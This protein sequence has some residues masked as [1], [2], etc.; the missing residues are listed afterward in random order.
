MSPEASLQVSYADE[1]VTEWSASVDD[2]QLQIRVK[3]APNSAATLVAAAPRRNK[4]LVKRVQ[5]DGSG[6]GVTVVKA[7]EMVPPPPVSTFFAE[8]LIYQAEQLTRALTPATVTATEV[9]EPNASNGR[10][11]RADF[12]A[13]GQRIEFTIDVPAGGLYEIEAR[14]KEN[15]SRGI[16]QPYVDGTLAG[17]EINHLYPGRVFRG[18]EFR[19]RK[20]AVRQL[21]AG[22]HTVA[23]ESTGKS[24]PSYAV[25]VDYLRLTPTAAQDRAVFEVESCRTGS[26]K[27]VDLIRDAAASPARNGACEDLP[28]TEIGDWVEYQ[29]TVPKPGSYRIS[30]MVKKHAV[31][32]Q[33]QLRVEDKPLGAVVDSYLPNSDG[34]YQYLEVSHGT[35][36]FDTA[37]AKA[38]RYVIAGKHPQ[39]SAFRLGL[40]YIA[41]TPVGHLA[42]D[43]P[44]TVRVRKQIQLQASS[45][46]LGVYASP[47]YLL[48]SV[49]GAADG[50]AAFVDQTGLIT[51]RQKGTA[52]VRV[53]SQVDLSVAASVTITVT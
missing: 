18:I 39:S 51:G 30:T 22:K 50:A 32:G 41:V 43:G 40:D 13:T 47:E 45:T 3:G 26:S 27:P 35:V 53:R 12:T 25:G 49:D 29:I 20:L 16:S 11:I 6:V 4:A 5:L 34:E 24:G 1:H 15:A 2:D 36:T 48:W 19:E 33:F 8:P 17:P 28:A 7:S 10:W 44:S 21:T 42:I 31:R 38:L 52:V 14:F 37:G 23:F 9:S 46:D